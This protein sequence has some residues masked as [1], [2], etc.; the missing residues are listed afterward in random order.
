MYASALQLLATGNMQN[1]SEVG[2]TVYF[3]YGD[4][5]LN[6]ALWLHFI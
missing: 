3:P 5:D 1:F 4:G 6:L 2:Y